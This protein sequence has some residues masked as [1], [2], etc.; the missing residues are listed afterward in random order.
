MG[1]SVPE[2]LG[3]DFRAI[4]CIFLFDIPL[5]TFHWNIFKIT[6][7]QTGHRAERS[8]SL[9]PRKAVF[10]FLF[11]ANESDTARRVPTNLHLAS[12]AQLEQPFRGNRSELVLFLHDGFCCPGGTF[13]TR[14]FSA[15]ICGHGVPCPYRTCCKIAEASIQKFRR[16]AQK[17]SA[18][19]L[20]RNFMLYLVQQHRRKESFNL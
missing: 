4:F 18:A 2:Q 3:E 15:E 14:F 16:D 10:S 7:Q 5:K 13:L 17:F 12:C 19:G 6:A 9:R 1:G 8:C 11:R 20:F